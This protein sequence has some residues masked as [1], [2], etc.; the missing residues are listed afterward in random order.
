M[1]GRTTWPGAVKKIERL[2][3]QRRE[4]QAVNIPNDW[5]V[6]QK[7]EEDADKAVQYLQDGRL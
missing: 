6:W 4:R 1:T 5:E 7:S 3:R 2:E